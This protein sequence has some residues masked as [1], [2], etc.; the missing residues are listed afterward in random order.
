VVEVRAKRAS[1]PI[2]V[3]AAA[4]V[5]LHLGV[6]PVDARG[7]H[8]LAT[9]YQAIGIYDDVTV[10]DQPDWSVHLRGDP[11]LDLDAIPVDEDNIAL[12]AARALCAHHGIADRGARIEIQKAI[13]VAGGLA[14]GSAD[15]AAT[16]LALDRLWALDT[17][18]AD[19]L[20]LAAGLG[21]DVP[22]ALIGGTASGLGHGEQVRPVDDEGSWWWVVLPHSE[23]MS[24]PAVYRHFD[25]LRGS[26]V[27][28]PELPDDLL[29]AL[30]VGDVGWLADELHNDLQDP[31]LD[32][33]PELQRTLDDGR[34]AGAR[35]TLL[36]GSGPTVLLLCEDQAHAQLVRMAMVDRG[37]AQAMV[38][39]APVPGV[40]EVTYA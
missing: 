36:S 39:P 2:T 13:P 23:G 21:S 12:Q 14:G 24:T 1:K 27:P 35:G 4:K 15:A 10:A 38:A 26:D 7:Y 29:R 18:D 28:Q 20:R 22:F 33:R 32:L 16:L 11:G 25:E 37:H 40:H 19:L 17:S 5:N 31:A 8:A 6:G 30:A 9:V 34:E 3:R